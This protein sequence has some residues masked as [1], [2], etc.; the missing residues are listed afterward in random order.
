MKI[1]LVNWYGSHLVDDLVLAGLK[2]LI[3]ISLVDN[4]EDASLVICS[5]HGIERVIKQA[6]FRRIPFVRRFFKTQYG[7]VSL[8]P[9]QTSLFVSIESPAWSGFLASGCD[10]GISHQFLPNVGNHYRLPY[11]YYSIDWS[12]H[13]ICNN[14]SSRLGVQ[15]KPEALAQTRAWNESLH[16]DRLAMISGHLNGFKAFFYNDLKTSF[17]IDLVGGANGS[18]DDK[19]SFL[20]NG[21]YL[22]SLCPESTAC[23]GYY[24]EKTL[25][26]WACSTIPVTCH[27]ELASQDFNPDS[28]INLYSS[29]P[30]GLSEALEEIIADKHKLKKIYTA[31]LFKRPPSIKPLICF[32]ENMLC[33]AEKRHK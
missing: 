32:L 3:P 22:L 30:F 12:D 4:I 31:P 18:I 28:Y 23:P 8:R 2:S 5:F 9:D 20:A 26:A 27:D 16:S 19:H 21:R 33:M 7:G 13:G 10:Y 17:D 6:G 29:I 11:W 24:T 14:S 15:T 1:K 25:E